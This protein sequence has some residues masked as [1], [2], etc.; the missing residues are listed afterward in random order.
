L[1]SCVEA[2][3]GQLAELGFPRE[4]RA[5]SAH[6]TLGRL[7]EDH[8]DGKVRAVV[9]SYKLTPTVQAVSS[10]TLMSSVL[11]PKGPTYAVVRRAALG[12]ANVE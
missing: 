3:E 12:G 10:L 7:R 8:S 2:V 6:I 9:A 5:F 4:D 11:S 1:L